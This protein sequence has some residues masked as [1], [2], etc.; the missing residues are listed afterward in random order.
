MLCKHSKSIFFV[1]E[2]NQK[3]YR[4]PEV[5]HSNSKEMEEGSQEDKRDYLSPAS[6][7][8]QFPN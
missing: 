4:L 6:Y 3:D 7:P 5:E 2:E 8:A 1:R